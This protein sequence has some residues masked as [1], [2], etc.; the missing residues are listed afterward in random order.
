MALRVDMHRQTLKKY[1]K[2][3]KKLQREAM[4][5]TRAAGRSGPRSG[6]LVRTDL[7]VPLYFGVRNF[8]V[9]GPAYS[10][11]RAHCVLFSSG[12]RVRDA[13]S[14][15]EERRSVLRIAAPSEW[16]RRGPVRP[17]SGPPGPW[18]GRIRDRDRRRIARETGSE[19]PMNVNGISEMR[20]V[21]VFAQ[22][23]G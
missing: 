23:T 15:V 13:M 6:A 19:P 5:G 21:G 11:E 16:L 14:S 22:A 2:E 12:S 17:E 4:M 8:C 1:I 20:A 9:R 10:I 3:A 7:S 18:G